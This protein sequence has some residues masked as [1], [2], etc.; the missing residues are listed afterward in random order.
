VAER[1]ILFR[2]GI[3]ANTVDSKTS[4]IIIFPLLRSPNEKPVP[5]VILAHLKPMEIGLSKLG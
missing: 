4:L 2:N 1:I 5:E 3:P